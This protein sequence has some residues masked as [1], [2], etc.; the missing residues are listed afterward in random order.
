MLL[1]DAPAVLVRSLQQLHTTGIGL[2]S[3]H[4]VALSAFAE[5]HK[6]ASRVLTLQGPL[7]GCRANQVL[8]QDPWPVPSSVALVDPLQLGVETMSQLNRSLHSVTILCIVDSCLD[9]S[10]LLNLVTDWS[11]L[12]MLEIS[13][14]QVDV[15]AISL[16]RHA[17]WPHLERLLLSSN[18]LG[19]ADMQHLVPCS[20][21]L[22]TFLIL[23]H[24]CIDVPSV[25]CIAQGQ[26][27][28]LTLLSLRGNNVDAA[29]ISY[30][31]QGNWPELTTLMLSDECLDEAAFMLLGISEAHRQLIV[32]CIESSC[33][34]YAH[35]PQFPGLK[36]NGV[37]IWKHFK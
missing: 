23:D 17:K 28:A 1:S 30:L 32:E 26:F 11:R 5:K 14:N 34:V 6:H 8:T 33:R 29:G 36:W 10:G 3:Q 2:S 4:C 37:H 7:T 15:N 18:K 25:S 35:L 22:L 24:E 13:N 12:R 16:I 31:V 27:P 21:P 19:V 20:W 9:T